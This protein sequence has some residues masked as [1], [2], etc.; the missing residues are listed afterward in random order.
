MSGAEQAGAT[1]DRTSLDG[2]DALL[3]VRGGW[4]REAVEADKEAG[5]VEATVCAGVEATVCAGF[6]DDAKGPEGG[7][8]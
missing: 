1:T 5:A 8:A 2:D 6:A 4:A 7:R 3:E